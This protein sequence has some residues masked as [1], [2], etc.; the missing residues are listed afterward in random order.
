MIGLTDV[1]KRVIL[2]GDVTRIPNASCMM[3]SRVWTEHIVETVKCPEFEN[4]INA[5]GK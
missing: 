2:P 4:A 5:V 1:E 3:K